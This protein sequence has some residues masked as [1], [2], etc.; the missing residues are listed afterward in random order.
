MSRTM[1]LIH[2]EHDREKLARWVEQAEPGTIVEF[3][4][5][6]ASTSKQNARLWALLTRLSRELRWHGEHYSPADWKD[7]MMHAYR[8]AKWMPDEKGGYVP[9]GRSTAALTAAEHA[10]LTRLIVAFAARQ[11]IDL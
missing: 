11:G 4:S 9:V 5:Y 1:L 8:G 6:A 10:E 3:S 2:D 7:Y